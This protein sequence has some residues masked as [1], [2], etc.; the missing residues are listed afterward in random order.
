MRASGS[1]TF[2]LQFGCPALEVGS[3]APRHGTTAGTWTPAPELYGGPGSFS[4]MAEGEKAMPN[5]SDQ[6]LEARA[7]RA[8]KR[9]GLMA[10]KSRW[11]RDSI[12]NFGGFRLVDPYLNSVVDGS[13]FELSAEDILELC[14][15]DPA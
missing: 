15:S 5:C 4:Q 8:A 13:R 1:L 6:A 12:D 11:R 3:I 9:V 14:H 10:Q 2:D 7:R